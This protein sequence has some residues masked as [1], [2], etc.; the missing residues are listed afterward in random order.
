MPNINANSF[1][2]VTVR[3]ELDLQITK[4][5]VIAGLV[6]ANQATALNPGDKVTLDQTTGYNFSFVAAAT[7]AN[8]IGLVM[9]DAK[10]SAPTAGTY[11]QVALFHPGVV[12]WL[13]AGASISVMAMCEYVSFAAKT[14]QTQSGGKAIGLALDP[15]TTG[16]LMRVLLRDAAQA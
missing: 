11:I 10:N 5:G 7:S 1:N 3:G 15:G 6:S 13:T 14:I 8:A 12:M 9:F 4:S 2:Q 16:Q